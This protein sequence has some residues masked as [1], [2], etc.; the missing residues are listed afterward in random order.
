MRFM[1]LPPQDLA[2]SIPAPPGLCL[3]RAGDQAAYKDRP[4]RTSPCIVGHSCGRSSE[5]RA[6]SA[7]LPF[8]RNSYPVTE[9]TTAQ[10]PRRPPSGTASG[11]VGVEDHPYNVIGLGRNFAGRRGGCAEDSQFEAESYRTIKQD[12]LKRVQ[13][14]I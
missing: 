12:F 7:P 1:P 10:L 8:R 4:G 3:Q 14:P 2:V 6:V 5:I 11:G 13:G 9:S